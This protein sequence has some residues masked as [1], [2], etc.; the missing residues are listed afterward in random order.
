MRSPVP[1]RF[2]TRSRSTGPKSP[3]SSFHTLVKINLASW[4]TSLRYRTRVST[5]ATLF[6]NFPRS[7]RF[8]RPLSDSTQTHFRSTQKASPLAR[9]VIVEQLCGFLPSSKYQNS[10][11]NYVLPF[12]CLIQNNKLP[13]HQILLDQEN[14]RIELTYDSA[15]VYGGGSY[16]SYN[17]PQSPKN[18]PLWNRL[19]QKVNQVSVHSLGTLSGIIACDGGSLVPVP[20][21]DPTSRNV[22]VG[23]R[24]KNFSVRISRNILRD[25]GKH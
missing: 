6:F 16:P 23:R 21:P 10:L 19:R 4:P 22:Y 17:I 15:R 14:T 25:F 12:L 1:A 7:F 24:G 11:N 2:H 8:W 3:T 5:I 20:D 9:L 13:R 18:N